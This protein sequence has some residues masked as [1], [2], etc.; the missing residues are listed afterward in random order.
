MFSKDIY[1]NRRNQLKSDVGSG[2][3]I[4]P[5]NGEASSNYKANTYNFRQD[6]N[7]LYFFGLNQPDYIGI[8][9]VD[10]DED[11]IYADE[12][13]MDDIIWMGHLPSVKELAARSGVSKT[14]SQND[15]SLLLTKAIS[16]GRKIHFV[17]PYR[18]DTSLVLSRLLGMQPSCLKNYQSEILIKSI[19]K[20]RS[21]K[22]EI[23][24]AEIEKAIDTAYKMHT[25]AMKMMHSGIY[26]YE[27]AGLMEGIA[28][29]N[30]GPV[31][32]PIILSM[33]GQTLHNHNHSQKL[34]EGRMVVVDAGCETAM[35]YCSDITRTIPVGGKFDARQQEIY[36]TVL[37]A[38]MKVFELAKPGIPYRDLHLEACRVLASNLK[39]IG[40]MKGD[41]DEAVHQGAH[42]LFMP[43]GL[44]HM[45]GLDVHDME[46][47][48]EMFV[49][50]SEDIERSRQFGLAFLRMGKKLEKGFVITNE[51]GCY[52]IPALIDMWKS[53]GKFKDFINYEQL[54]SYKDFGGIRIEDDLLITENANRLLGTPIP[55]TIAAVENMVNTK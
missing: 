53:E 48:G 30:G 24:I 20:Q 5:A 35:N 2:L 45:M 43:H 8:I 6:S 39:D 44:G 55:K 33:D 31:S 23:E 38:N 42:A 12:L 22:S 17:N 47:L 27:I 34:V 49:G 19:V 51:P 7:F 15:L 1:V 50:Y 32:F 4:F 26:E 16:D 21:I 9:D 46:N 3:I 36:A 29:A 40:L 54:E 28:L 10:N 41:I 18:G 14:A 52:F 13:T 37:A 25:T 11:W